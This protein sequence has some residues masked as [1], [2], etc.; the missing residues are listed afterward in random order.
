MIYYYTMAAEK[1]VGRINDIIIILSLYRNWYIIIYYIAWSPVREHAR[2]VK[3]RGICVV[4]CLQ[5]NN[6]NNNCYGNRI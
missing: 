2:H 1:R 5:C 3:S 6:N 4:F